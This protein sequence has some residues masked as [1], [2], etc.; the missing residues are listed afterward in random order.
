MPIDR[1]V[2]II[3]SNNIKPTFSL[4]GSLSAAVISYNSEYLQSLQEMIFMSA[5]VPI[6]WARKCRGSAKFLLSH[7]GHLPLFIS[8]SKEPVHITPPQNEI[9]T[10]GI[11]QPQT[12]CEVGGYYARV[13]VSYSIGWD[14]AQYLP[15]WM[16]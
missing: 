12:L 7:F 3:I 8:T 15:C 2:G 16:L 13:L 9:L 14:D 10:T 5:L 11:R 6:P 1:R 4:T